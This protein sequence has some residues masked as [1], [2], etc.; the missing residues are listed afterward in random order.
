VEDYKIVIYIVLGI[1][2]FLF[3]GKKKKPNTPANQPPVK[4]REEVWDKPP[5]VTSKPMAPKPT[6]STPK[7]TP[8]PEPYSLEDILKQFGQTLEVKE[9]QKSQEVKEIRAE[10]LEIPKGKI[11]D[12][13]EDI[14]VEE[15]SLEKASSA[16]KK[17][18]IGIWEGRSFYSLRIRSRIKEQVCSYVERSGGN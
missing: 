17:Y 16:K 15:D 9:E 13:D 2:Y 11:I 10:T 14:A 7:N 4:Q 18:R 5:V 8:S 12:Y 1:L 3:S 6:V